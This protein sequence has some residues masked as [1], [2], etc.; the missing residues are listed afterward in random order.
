MSTPRC[1]IFAPNL[2]FN[3]LS[4]LCTKIEKKKKNVTHVFGNC[5]LQF[6]VHPSTLDFLPDVGINPYGLKYA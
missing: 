4:F 1:R 5:V 3:Y 2:N 6:G